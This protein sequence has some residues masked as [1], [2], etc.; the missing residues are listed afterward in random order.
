MRGEEIMSITTSE[1]QPIERVSVAQPRWRWYHAVAFYGVVQVLTF[2]LSGLVSL[3]RGNKSQ[4][5]REATFGDVSYFERLK[6]VKITPPSWAF[7]PAWLVNNIAVIWGTWH[8]LNKP[9][10]TPGRTTYL[11]LQGVSWIDFVLFNAAYFSLRSPLNALALTLVM[12]LLTIA[13]GVVAIFRL[14][15]TKVALSLATLFLW[16]LVALTAATFQALWNKD[17]FYQVGPLVKPMA[18]L[19]KKEA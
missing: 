5:L 11:A 7:G 19:V 4:S 9:R 2:G 13:S 12:F 17:D 10:Q 14:K 18:G 1:V 8:V 6:Q 15:D 3:A 16:L